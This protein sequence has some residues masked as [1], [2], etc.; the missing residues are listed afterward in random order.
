MEIVDDLTMTFTLAAPYAD[1]PVMLGAP[2]G[3]IVDPA[4][5]QA[6]GP[7]AMNA[8]Q[9]PGAGAGPYEVESWDRAVG[10]VLNRKADYWGPTPCVEKYE[11]LFITDNQTRNDAFVNGEV[12]AIY[13][14]GPNPNRLIKESNPPDVDSFCQVVNNGQDLVINAGAQGA[15]RPGK[16]LRVRQAIGLAL[17]PTVINER[18]NHGAG[19][20]SKAFLDQDSAFFSDGIEPL[21]YDPAEATRLLDEAKAEGYDGHLYYPTSN[22]PD[23]VDLALIVE[24]QLEAVGFDVELNS[25]FDTAGISQLLL[26]TNDYDIVGSAM[27]AFDSDILGE[28]NRRVTPWT[29]FE[30][31]EW[32]AAKDALGVAYGTEA[33][34]EALAQISEV[35]N[36]QVPWVTLDHHDVC[37]YWH[38]DI[39]GFGFSKAGFYTVDRVVPAGD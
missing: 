32:T 8:G 28:I 6:V 16:D 36:E 39:E 2:I 24:A 5:A 11:E 9:A 21:A 18:V 3:S 34:Q 25:T 30:S 38:N 26:T 29:G 4:V 13:L 31:P 35:W 33:K 14:R 19:R 15:D 17:D 7:D 1:F 20:P 27:S 12:D 10:V 37:V 22:T 23:A